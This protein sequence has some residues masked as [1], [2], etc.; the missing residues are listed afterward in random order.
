[1]QASWIIGGMEKERNT[2]KDLQAAAEFIH[3]MLAY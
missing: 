1:M 2:Y 3:E